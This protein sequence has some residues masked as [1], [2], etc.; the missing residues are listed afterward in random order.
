MLTDN[1]REMKE[2]LRYLNGV[3]AKRLI[4]YLK[5]NAYESSLPKLRVQELITDP[6]KRRD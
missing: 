4:N 5:E 6:Q 3:S 2:V 1:S